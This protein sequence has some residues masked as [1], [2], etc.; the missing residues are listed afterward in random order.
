MIR[1]EIAFTLVI[2]E[3]F[4]A[5]FSRSLFFPFFPRVGDEL[6]IATDLRI[7]VFGSAWDVDESF[8]RI[9]G[10]PVFNAQIDFQEVLSQLD[11][12]G[13]YMDSISEELLTK[14]AS[15]IPSR[16]KGAKVE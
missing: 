8:A 14:Y 11:S 13:W 9:A 4:G 16:F 5:R 1:V 7:K 10:A 3:N 6:I 12:S 15:V 2:E